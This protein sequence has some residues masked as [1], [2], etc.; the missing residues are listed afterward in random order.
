MSV[1]VLT[2]GLAPRLR[3]RWHFAVFLAALVG[4]TRLLDCAADIV[5]FSTLAAGLKT[6]IFEA[7]VSALAVLPFTY[8]AARLRASPEASEQKIKLSGRLAA[9]WALLLMLLAAVNFALVKM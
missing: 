4:S 8:L 1:A 9:S 7:A 6:G 3:S 2:W 5:H